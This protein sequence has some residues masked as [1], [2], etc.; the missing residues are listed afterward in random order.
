MASRCCAYL[1]ARQP[2]VGRTGSGPPT[3]GRPG[4]LHLG[5]DRLSDEDMAR[6]VHAWIPGSRG[7]TPAPGAGLRRRSTAAGGRS[8][9]IA[10]AAGVVHRD[11]PRAPGLLQRTAAIGDRGRCHPRPSLRLGTAPDR[12]RPD[13]GP[14]GGDARARGRATAGE[15][16]RHGLPLPARADPRS[17][18]R[19]HAATPP[20]GPGLGGARRSGRRTPA[21]GRRPARAGR[22]AGEP[23]RGPPP[24][25]NAAER[26]RRPGA[27]LG[28]AGH[29]DRYPTACR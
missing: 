27:G 13:C 3:A 15:R 16:R 12:Q 28:G 4:V 6:M 2:A 24:G 25:W 21:P 23:C 29:R 9:G 1:P 20:A 18:A 14:G 5:L 22:R 7:G 10:R 17:G 19:Y 26:V 11:G 8:A